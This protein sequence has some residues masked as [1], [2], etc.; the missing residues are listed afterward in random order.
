MTYPLISEYKAAIL[1]AEDN[2]AT[3]TALRPVCDINGEPIMTSGN[4][5][6]VFKMEDTQTGRLYAVKCFLRDQERRESSYEKISRA[7]SIYPKIYWTSF[8]YLDKELFVDSR[9]A[10]ETEF[11]IVL[12]DWIDGTDLGTF[13]EGH[14]RDSFAMA[15]IT[16]EFSK[17]AKWICGLPIAHGDVKPDNVIVSP[18]SSKL[19]LVDYDGMYVPEMEGEEPRELGS[20]NFRHPFRDSKIYDSYIDDFSFALICM[21]LRAITLDPLIYEEFGS[22]DH[23]LLNEAD[24]IDSSAPI[25]TR[26]RDY[27]NDEYFR[28][29]AR[30]FDSALK[31]GDLRFIS[32]SNFSI[33][34]PN[35]GLAVCSRKVSADSIH[36]NGGVLSHFEDNSIEVLIEGH[37][38]VIKSFAFNNCKTLEKVVFPN[39]LEEISADAFYHCASL[40]EL[41]FRN[42]PRMVDKRA[43][44]FCGNIQRIFIPEGTKESFEKLGALAYY[45]LIEK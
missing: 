16:Y 36:D 18:D 31:Y 45:N 33:P 27:L 14:F 38:K 10:D 44:H 26:L 9:S 35:Q 25:K 22:P 43:F 3:Q 23:L 19:V 12:M 11:P 20:P 4:Y 30:L 32:L 21:S 8:Q 34:E 29:F 7:L 1:A 40:K 17:M 39:G 37:V 5:A 28:D 42:L 41:V 2:L 13:V 6:V 15:R 24:I